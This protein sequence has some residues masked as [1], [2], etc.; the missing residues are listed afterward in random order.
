M[1][2]LTNADLYN[3][4]QLL[5]QDIEYMKDGQAKMQSDLT[6]I[7]KTLL[8]PDAGTIA[9]VNQNTN[10]RKSAQK[11]LWSIWIALIGI[12]GKMIFWN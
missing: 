2:R 1:P 6:M 12:I 3:D 7:K 9:R 10:F 4:I 8:D 5:K 11:T